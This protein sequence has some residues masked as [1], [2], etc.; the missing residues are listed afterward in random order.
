MAHAGSAD[1]G[2]ALVEAAAHALAS[3]VKELGESS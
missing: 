1:K 3:L 2:R